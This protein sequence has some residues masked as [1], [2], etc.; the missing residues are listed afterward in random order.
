M[1]LARSY[2][3]ALYVLWLVLVITPPAAA[4][5]PEGQRE[6]ASGKCEPIPQCGPDQEEVQGRCFAKCA[7]GQTRDTQ[8]KCRAA[9]GRRR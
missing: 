6:G 4:S 3:H 1:V 7:A 5:C 9:T 8:G 2:I